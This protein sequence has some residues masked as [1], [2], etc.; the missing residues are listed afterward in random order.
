[1]ENRTCLDQTRLGSTPDMA[2]PTF[3]R[4]GVIHA[5]HVKRAKSL[6][7]TAFSLKSR[8]MN[9]DLAKH[10]P[11]D[12]KITFLNHGSFGSCP[13]AVLEYQQG[14][15]DRMERQPVQFLARDLEELLDAA[16]AALAR[17]VGAQADDLVFTGNATSGVNTVLRSLTFAPGD[18]L[19]VTDHEYNACRN[20]L[21]YV[22]GR[23]GATVVVAAIPFPL[24]SV[25]E[26]VRA[27][28]SKVTPRTRLALIDHVTSPSALVLP[29][30]RLVRELADR[31]IDTLVD[32]AHA[33]GMVPLDLAALGAAYYTGN[34]HKWLCAPKAA[35][36]LHVRPDRQ[37]FVHP[38]SISHGLNSRRTDRSRFLIEF[39]WTGTS[40]P[41]ACL[42][43]GEILRFMGGLVPGG[44]PEIMAKNRVLA[45]AAQKILCQSLQI[46]PPCPKICIGS[47]AAL[48]LPDNPPAKGGAMPPFPDPLQDALLAN[49][50]IEVP[51]MPW[52]GFPKRLVRISAQLYNSLPQY[53]LLAEALP[54]ALGASS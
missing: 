25:E 53:Q 27:I 44:W 1:M 7:C 14:L 37:E 54:V 12:P 13:R 28:L 33:P 34:C 38:L 35:G 36:F 47:M 30:A 18:E 50:G 29:I 46:D 45:L 5:Y 20:A 32:G 15:R 3:G 21:D 6:S 19:L 24:D 48:P 40:D 43:V 10:W 22:A 8:R 41:T 11:L 39:G 26:I 42:A 52:P 49:H 4:P 17:F 31:G 2:S 16:R 51:V 23:T 9:S